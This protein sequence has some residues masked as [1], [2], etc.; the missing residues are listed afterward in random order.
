M[1]MTPY[2]WQPSDAQYPKKPAP[3]PKGAMTYPRQMQTMDPTVRPFTGMKTVDPNKGWTSPV[4]GNIQGAINTYESIKAD[5]PTGKWGVMHAG[6]QQQP[7]GSDSWRD[8]VYADRMKNSQPYSRGGS[9]AT[10][11][12]A[13]AAAIP[14]PE[15]PEFKSREFAP[16]AEDPGVYNRERAI[17]M[18]PGLRALKEGTR[19]AINVAQS[20]DNPNARGRFIKQALQGYGQ[21]LENV[22]AQAHRS[23]TAE[24]GRKRN[25]QLEIYRTNWAAKNDAY[26]MN[27]KNQITQIA[28]QYANDQQAAASGMMPSGGQSLSGTQLPQ[29]STKLSMYR[30]AGNQGRYIPGYSGR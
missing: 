18:G 4:Q 15:M 22:S 25:E 5:A 20:L 29:L 10:Q 9:G 27:Y 3:S 21:G 30:A 28:Q 7:Q 19:E 8:R 2:Q 1:T 17:A 26:L 13:A 12:T 24:A 16:P 23:A 6:A 11:N 14:V